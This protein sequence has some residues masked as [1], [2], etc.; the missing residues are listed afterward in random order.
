LKTKD[1]YNL[2]A[3]SQAA[4]RAALSDYDAMRANAERVRATRVRLTEALKAMGFRVAPSQANFVLAQWAGEPTA[5]EIYET[6]KERRIFVR[7]FSARRL[8][9]ALRITV[10]TDAEIDALLS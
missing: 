4:A 1:S 6:L 5:R 3:C 10:G 9:D 7:Y 8:D 2:N